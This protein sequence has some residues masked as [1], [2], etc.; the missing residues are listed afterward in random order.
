MRLRCFTFFPGLSSAAIPHSTR[1]R[2]SGFLLW[3]E[4]SYSLVSPSFDVILLRSARN[5]KCIVVLCVI[6]LQICLFLQEFSIYVLLAFKAD[7][8]SQGNL[9][10]LM[11]S[12]RYRFH[13]NFNSFN[14]QLRAIFY[15]QE[16]EFPTRSVRFLFRQHQVRRCE[17]WNFPLFLLRCNVMINEGWN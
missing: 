14:Q 13:F 3:N 16:S 17:Q 10:I 8:G 12:W 7:D 4:N 5:V 2:L 1:D 9:Y 15:R 11:A 6:N